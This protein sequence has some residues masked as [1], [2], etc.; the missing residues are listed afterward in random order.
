MF[1]VKR[2]HHNPIF[3]PDR[4][5][6]WESFAA[7]N[8]SPIK[9]KGKIYGLYR[10]ISSKGTLQTPERRSVIGIASSKDGT[11][12]GNRAPFIVPQ[13]PW[14]RFGCEDPRVTFFE[15]S[16]YIFY[17]A[18]SRYPFGPDGIKVAVAVSRDLKKISERHLITPFNA[19]AMALFPERVGGKVT[20]IVTAHTD[21]P[22]A[23]IAIVQADAM[24]ELWSPQ[25]W[26]RWHARIGGE[27][28]DPRRTPHDHVEVGAAPIKTKYGWLLIYSHID[29]KSTRLNSSH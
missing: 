11:H 3:V 14:E 22:P 21:S 26:E 28:L 18:L 16:Y 7:F 2:S 10:A 19:K 12:F 17:T 29:R 20:A 1:V 8:L 9:H 5:H 25:F 13:E 24:E 6:S 4:E 23:K 15:G 27:A